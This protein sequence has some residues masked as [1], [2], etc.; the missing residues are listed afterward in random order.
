MISIMRFVFNKDFMEDKTSSSAIL[1]HKT[2]INLMKSIARQRSAIGY[3]SLAFDSQRVRPIA[4]D[5]IKPTRKNAIAGE[6]PY[7]RSLNFL[8]KGPQKDVANDFIAFTL[9]NQGQRIV[10]RHHIALR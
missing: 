4:I 3:V 7:V 8:T 10:A 6:Y 2:D 1:E 5:G 9:S